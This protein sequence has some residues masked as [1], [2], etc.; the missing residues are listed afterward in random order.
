MRLVYPIVK[1]Y[2][3]HRGLSYPTDYMTFH[4]NR[5]LKNRYIVVDFGEMSQIAEECEQSQPAEERDFEEGV[6]VI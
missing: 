3:I 4:L 6:K 2:V 1:T 5:Y